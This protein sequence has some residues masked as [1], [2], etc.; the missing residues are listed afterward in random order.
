MFA[1]LTTT[2]DR[3]GF[4]VVVARILTS[5]SGMSLDTF[6][7]LPLHDTGEAPEVRAAHANRVLTEMLS[8]PAVVLHPP[9][10]AVSLALKHFRVPPRV[11]LHDMGDGLRTQ[12]VLVGTDRPGLSPMSLVY[13]ASTGCA[14]TM[15][16]SPPSASAP[17]I[18]S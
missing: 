9:R 1:T 13:C 7:L 18:C 6:Q 8:R 12:L 17:R 16:G 2:L 15:P 10:R 4:S 11:E 3:L 5:T 14:C